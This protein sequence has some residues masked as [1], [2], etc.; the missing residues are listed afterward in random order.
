MPLHDYKCRHCNAIRDNL[1]F[2]LIDI[3]KDN[4]LGCNECG[5]QRCMEQFFSLGK[6]IAS[7][8]TQ[9]GGGYE[10]GYGRYHPQ[11]GCIMESYSHKKE[12]M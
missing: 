10:L 1:Y 4:R 9:N 11:F 8:S 7:K 2:K 6:G 5:K 12:L 3:P